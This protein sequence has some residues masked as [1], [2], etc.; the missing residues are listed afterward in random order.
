MCLTAEQY[1]Q[2]A[3]AYEKAA[4]DETRPS[5]L[6]TAFV[7]KAKWFRMLCQI[8]AAE[9][10]SPARAGEA[11]PDIKHGDGNSSR[12][13]LRATA[14]MHQLSLRVKG[15]CRLNFIARKRLLL[16]CRRKAPLHR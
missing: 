16:L 8:D 12:T 13:D 9:K 1:S 2:I 6:R 5:Q 14:D 15:G 11:S 7:K 3:S 10:L 4:A